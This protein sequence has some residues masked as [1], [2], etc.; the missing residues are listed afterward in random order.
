M[1]YCYARV[2]T[3][4]Q[5]LDRQINAFKPYEPYVLYTDKES[6]KDFDRTNYKKMKRK[7]KEGDTII[8]LSLDRFGRNYDQIKQEWQDF[9]SKNIKIKVLDMPLIDTTNNDLT[10]KL[11]SDIVLQLLS[12][13]AQTEYEKIHE[14]Q[15]QGIAAARARGVK[16][17]RPRKEVPKELLENYKQG[18]YKAVAQNLKECGISRQTF[19][20]EIKKNA[21]YARKREKRNVVKNT[22]L[23]KL[24]E[25]R[26]QI[27]EHKISM[28]QVMEYC[29]SDSNKIIKKLKQMG[30][31]NSSCIKY[32]YQAICDNEV[33]YNFNS[34]VEAAVILGVSRDAIIRHMNGEKTCLDELDIKVI[35]I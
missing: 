9:N 33:V 28:Q 2:S 23:K 4:Q 25:L 29:N 15:A 24:E 14:R 16:L 7:V 6:G 19:F 31:K 32:K 18:G 10:S 8:V 12:Y 27:E 22:L 1:N 21:T 3:A 26:P 35:K 13:V 20:R 34:L 11:I 17:G 30:V 5:N